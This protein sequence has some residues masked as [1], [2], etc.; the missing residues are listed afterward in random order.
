M[1]KADRKGGERVRFG[2][3]TPILSVRDMAVSVR[4]YVE[5]L[6]FTNADWGNDDFTM[7]TR[8]RAA[9][10]LCRGAQGQPGTWVWVGVGDS[11]ALYEEY[12]A[13]GA[14][15][16]QPPV[17]RPWALEFSVEDPDGH[18]LRLGSDPDDDEERG[19][20]R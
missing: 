9:I 14:K 4:Y 3:A 7:L 12:R 6:G 1:S 13:S 16:L 17:L 10:Y 5:V 19:D 20:D 2:N 18:V 8:D 11:A 15:I